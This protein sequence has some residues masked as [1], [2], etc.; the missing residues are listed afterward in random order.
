[1]M[2]MMDGECGN[3]AKKEGPFSLPVDYE[4]L[5]RRMC[6]LLAADKVLNLARSV[7]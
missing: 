1:M 5:L 4:F 2:E 6:W 7:H 3:G